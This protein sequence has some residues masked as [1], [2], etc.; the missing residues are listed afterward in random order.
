VREQ[1]NYSIQDMARRLGLSHSGY[2]KN[3]SGITFPKL[4]TLA[5]LHEEYDISM[6]WLIFNQEPMHNKDRQP[7]QGEEKETLDRGDVSSDVRELLEYMDQDPL[8]RYE[9]L[10]YFYKYKRKQ[11]PEMEETPPLPNGE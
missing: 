11:V 2:F 5:R 7:E 6:D 8:L 9:V 3:E 4:N 10:V 1:L